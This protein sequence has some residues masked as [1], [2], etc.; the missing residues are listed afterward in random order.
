MK[1][2]IIATC[3]IAAGASFSGTVLADQ[4]CGQIT[5]KNIT[6][7]S[8]SIYPAFIYKVDGK[9]IMGQ[10]QTMNLPVGTHEIELKE[11]IDDQTVRRF[12]QLNGTSEAKTLTLNVS[13]DKKYAL[14]SKFNRDAK[15][16]IRT[17]QHWTP[18]V[19]KEYDKSCEF[20]WHDSKA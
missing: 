1:H 8:Q 13:A 20:S 15:S 16:Q 5:V 12:R 10:R 9:N 4:Q 17:G 2:I 3:L 6:K 18:V 7:E 14:A 11:M 19:W